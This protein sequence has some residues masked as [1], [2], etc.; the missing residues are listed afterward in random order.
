MNYSVFLY[1]VKKERV[2]A[3]RLAEKAV[4]KAEDNMD[5]LEEEESLKEVNEIIDLIK[6]NITKWDVEI[7]NIWIYIMF[8]D[9]LCI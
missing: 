5:S 9:I 3:S 1:E 7:E 6:E 8:M 4:S 2:M